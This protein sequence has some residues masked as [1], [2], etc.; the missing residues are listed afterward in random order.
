MDIQAV[1]NYYKAVSYTC[2]YFSKSE[3]KSSDAIRILQNTSESK[4]SSLG[5][6]DCMRAAASSFSCSY[7]VSIQ[8]AAILASPELWLH[9]SY[10]KTIFVDSSITFKKVLYVQIKR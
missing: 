6:M 3:S 7:E 5:V 1:T 9:K 4:K 10:P 8:E 2:S